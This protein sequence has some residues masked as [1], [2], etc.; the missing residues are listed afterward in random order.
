MGCR[1]LNP[2]WCLTSQCASRSVRNVRRG[3]GPRGLS[4]DEWA[5]FCR[6]AP[7]YDLHH[8]VLGEAKIAADQAIGQA[9]AVHGEH[10]LCFLVRGT[11]T[12]LA[13]QNDTTGLEKQEI[14]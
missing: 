11:L 14:S 1:D 3:A 9:V 7:P 4:G 8:G 2:A 6:R 13:A 10:L 5:P 12:D